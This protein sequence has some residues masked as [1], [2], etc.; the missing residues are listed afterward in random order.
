MVG[1]GVATMV[2]AT[3]GGGVGGTVGEVVGAGEGDGLGRSTRVGDG[4][5]ITG[6]GSGDGVGAAVWAGTALRVDVATGAEAGVEVRVGPAWGE[7]QPAMAI[8]MIVSASHGMFRCIIAP[9]FPVDVPTRPGPDLC[10]CGLSAPYAPVY[11]IN[12]VYHTVFGHNRNGTFGLVGTYGA[13]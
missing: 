11:T 2:G 3:V 6:R 13:S 10:N 8:T 12:S 4:V 9:R 5:G 7:L 1:V